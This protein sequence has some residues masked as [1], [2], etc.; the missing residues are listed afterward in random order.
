M[1]DR[2]RTYDSNTRRKANKAFLQNEKNILERNYTN[3]IGVVTKLNTGPN[4]HQAKWC[5]VKLIPTLSYKEFS[6]QE[7]YVSVDVIQ[8]EKVN[9][10]IPVDVSVSLRDIVLINF[11]DVNFRKTILDILNGF[12]DDSTFVEKDQTKNSINFGIITNR[13]LNAQ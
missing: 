12:P 11:T 1:G 6:R 3:Y 9:A 2:I 8:N 5:E 4:P 10:F 13:I 7:G